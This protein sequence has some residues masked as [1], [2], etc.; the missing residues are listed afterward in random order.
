MQDLPRGIPRAKH[1]IWNK[2]LSTI[3]VRSADELIIC[4]SLNGLKSKSQRSPLHLMSFHAR[5]LVSSQERELSRHSSR[6]IV[7][8][9]QNRT[10]T[11]SCRK[12]EVL[13]I[14]LDIILISCCRSNTESL[15]YLFSYNMSLKKCRVRLRPGQQTCLYLAR[16]VKSIYCKYEQGYT[17]NI[18]LLHETICSSPHPSCEIGGSQ[19]T[20][21]DITQVHSNQFKNSSTPFA[22]YTASSIDHTITR[23]P[24]MK[25]F[26]DRSPLPPASFQTYQHGQVR[27][28]WM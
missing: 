1:V 20:K 2:I 9:D 11:S 13:R 26:P 24:M 15:I 7:G 6:S 8:S 10:T 28:L 14:S 5:L 22:T 21:F 16:G 17:Q 27:F 23:Y 25:F 3:I 12:S 4:S 18:T 19:Q